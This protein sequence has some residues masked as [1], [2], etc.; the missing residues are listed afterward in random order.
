MACP[1]SKADYSSANVS[2]VLGFIVPLIGKS[3]VGTAARFPDCGQILDV[4]YTGG[5]LAS[6]C[7]PASRVSPEQRRYELFAKRSKRLKDFETASPAGITYFN[8]DICW[9]L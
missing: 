6:E 2:P 9:V 1:E 4:P 3:P 7:I 5:N 8:P